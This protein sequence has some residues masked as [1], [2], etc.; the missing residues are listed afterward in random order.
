M[1][2]A[3]V[4][5][6]MN[7]CSRLITLFSLAIS[8]ILLSACNQGGIVATNYTGLTAQEIAENPQYIQCEKPEVVY[9][10]GDQLNLDRISYSAYKHGYAYIGGTVLTTERNFRDH[11]S[12]AIATAEELGACLIY[13]GQVGFSHSESYSVTRSYDTVVG[14]VPGYGTSFPIMQTNYYTEYYD[15]DYYN[16]RFYFFTQLNP[17]MDY[18][19]L[20]HQLS[21]AQAAEINAKSGLFVLHVKPGS[22]ADLDGFKVGDKIIGT[23][24]NTACTHGTFYTSGCQTNNT[25][26][27]Y[28]NNRK[29]TLKV[30]G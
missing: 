28:R 9:L 14:M 5:K 26:T 23:N 13:W 10:E 18:G 6:N 16:Y 8:S 15:V 12:R 4:D 27:I 2:F 7:P 22:Q 11:R 20:L 3:L 29:M 1:T 17:E 30:S 25:Y 24:R 19:I 21:D